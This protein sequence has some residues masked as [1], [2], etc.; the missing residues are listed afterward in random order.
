MNSDFITQLIT[1]GLSGGIFGVAIL[2]FTRTWIS[3]R[4]RQSIQSEY[5]HK[6]VLYKADIDR[7][8]STELENL[9]SQLKIEALEH[10]IKFSNLHEKRAE[11]ISETYSL[12]KILFIATSDYVRVLVNDGVPSIEERRK[13]VDDA[14]NKFIYFYHRNL[15]FLPKTISNDIFQIKND[16]YKV[17]QNYYFKVENGGNN[18]SYIEDW[19]KI[20]EDVNKKIK[21]ALDQLE[22]EFRDLL[23]DNQKK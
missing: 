16:L 12:L 14:Y 22:D 23:G 6:L 1:G 21:I 5:D 18:E 19:S 9:K 15:I 4:L 10:E 17:I 3:E 7:H 2:W 13:I 20:H 8:T 11:V